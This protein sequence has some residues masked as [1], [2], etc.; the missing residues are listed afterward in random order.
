MLV[1]VVGRIAAVKFLEAMFVSV[2]S[3]VRAVTEVGS[4]LGASNSA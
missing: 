1:S 4:L 3:S 2:D